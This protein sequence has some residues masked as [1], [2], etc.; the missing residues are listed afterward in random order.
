MGLVI[1]ALFAL[2]VLLLGFWLWSLQRSIAQD[3]AD[4]EKVR[5]QSEREAALNRKGERLRCLNC[6]KTFRGPLPSTGCPNCHL[7]SFVVP[8]AEY[9]ENGPKNKKG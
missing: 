7:T 1:E 2:G 6:E 5:R 4:A 8:V 3:R 9:R